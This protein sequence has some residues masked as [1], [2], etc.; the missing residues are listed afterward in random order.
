MKYFFLTA[1]LLVAA[2]LQAGFTNSGCLQTKNLNLKVGDLLDNNGQLI[3]IE[4]ITVEADKIVGKG[5]IR[6]PQI[7]IRTALFA[8]TGTIDCSEKCTIYVKEPFNERMFHRAG[9][10]KFQIIVDKN[11]GK[12]P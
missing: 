4:S 5:L 2:C 3:G 11:L 10:G 9:K 6:S 12:T 1:L 8:F 7:T